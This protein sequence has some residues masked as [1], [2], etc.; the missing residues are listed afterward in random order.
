MQKYKYNSNFFKTWSHDMAYILG[1]IMAD[2]SISKRDVLDIENKIIDLSILEFI[3]DNLG[4][5]LELRFINKKHSESKKIQNIV[6]LTIYDKIIVE[7][8]KNLSVINC[9]TGKECIPEQC[10]EEYIFDF[11]RGFFDGD[12]HVSNKTTV[13][14]QVAIGSSSYKIV[15]QIHQIVKLGSIYKKGKQDFWYWTISNYKDIMKFH[16]MIYN[17]HFYLDRKKIRFEEM[18]PS[19]PMN[20]TQGKL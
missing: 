15:D 10:P 19:R 9:K 14:K 20:I 7:D 16:D 6:R 5:N 12:G 4:S 11:I 13:S 2:G 18:I 3:R 17:G 8:L 1:F